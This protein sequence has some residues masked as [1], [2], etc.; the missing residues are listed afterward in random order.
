MYEILKSEFKNY[1]EIEVDIR[2]T[3]GLY[4]LYQGRGQ[5]WNNLDEKDYEPIRKISNYIKK[6]IKEEARFMFSN[7]P[8]FLVTNKEGEPL[9]EYQKILDNILNNNLFENKII[10]GARDCFI[11]KRIA[12]KV[13]IIDGEPIVT[14]VPSTNFAYETMENRTDKLNKVIFFEKT[15]QA[16]NRSDE[17][18]WKQKYEIINGTCYL[19]EEILD[20]NFRQLE[21]IR[22]EENL[23]INEIPCYIILNDGLSHDMFGESDV[24]EIIDNAI[25][26]NKMASEDLDTLR[27]GMNRIIYGI[28][29]DEDAIKQFKLKPGAFWDAT[30]DITADGKQAT[31]GTI[32]T[33]FGY[34]ERMESALKRIKADMYE[35][36][37]IPMISS[38]DLKGVLTSGK[39][40]KALYWQLITRC[41][42]KFIAWKPALRWLAKF[43]LLSSNKNVENIRIDVINN[44]PLQEDKDTEKQLDLQQVNT[45]V[46]SRKAYIMKWLDK[47]EDAAEEEIKQIKLEQDLLEDSY[48]N[49]EMGENIE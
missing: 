1:N 40:M 43:I 33:D 34:N 19:T 15:V 21:V 9:Q 48:T 10:K 47:K 14:F 28:D 23:K 35:V 8:N 22:Q 16:T 11:S 24:A 45:Q 4:E 37:N 6:L 32:S 26:Y 42:E 36:L 17:R 39:A 29:I 20:G 27:K 41:E 30:S 18:I 7:T 38:E 3:I 13:N 44:Y 5:N 46:M 2:H 31:I 12:I 49:F 25:M